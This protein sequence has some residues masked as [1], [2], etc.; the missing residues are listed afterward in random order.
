MLA[1]T[2]RVGIV[3]DLNNQALLSSDISVLFSHREEFRRR[4][5]VTN[6]LNDI[7][8]MKEQIQECLKL[9]DEIQEIKQLLHN[10]IQRENTCLA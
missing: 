9:R 4:Q 8:I 6:G 1:K 3:R 7:N 5:E 2:D 10:H